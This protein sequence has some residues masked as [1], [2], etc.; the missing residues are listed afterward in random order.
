MEKFDK[1]LYEYKLS[2]GY[3]V[4]NGFCCTHDTANNMIQKYLN[5]INDHQKRKLIF[6]VLKYNGSANKTLNRFF[7]SIPNEWYSEYEKFYADQKIKV[8]SIDLIDNVSI[9]YIINNLPIK[10]ISTKLNVSI[11][12]VQNI[13][14]SLNLKEQKQY[15][16]NEILLS[17]IPQENIQFIKDY[18]PH[19][20]SKKLQLL[21]YDK[22]NIS[23]VRKIFN[24][25][26][27]PRNEQLCSS[28]QQVREKYKKSSTCKSC[29]NKAMKEYQVMYYPVKMMLSKSDKDTRNDLLKNV[30]GNND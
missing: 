24:L 4:N 16:I 3:L 2:S 7:K 10:H 13:V 23:T 1:A 25:K 6:L 29:H 17:T 30:F 26:K 9:E 20:G 22:N 21:G 14:I 28:C 11:L 5:T 19:Y 12:T 15:H 27:L 8:L 18:Y